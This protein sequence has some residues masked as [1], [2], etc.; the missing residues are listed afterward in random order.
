MSSCRSL[1]VQLAAAF[2]IACDE[3][4]SA[5]CISAP[6]TCASKSI[7]CL[8]T[9]CIHTTPENTGTTINS[10][11]VP[12]YPN[13]GAKTQCICVLVWCSPPFAWLNKQMVKR[14]LAT[15]YEE[16]CAPFFVECMYALYR[17]ARYVFTEPFG[18]LLCS[19]NVII[20]HMLYLLLYWGRVNRRLTFSVRLSS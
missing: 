6:C 2:A 19:N 10:P 11:F 12:G 8:P 1:N 16:Y 7:P 3:M 5:R 14:V 9:R 18:T 13:N 17:Y 20:A 15:V 4:D